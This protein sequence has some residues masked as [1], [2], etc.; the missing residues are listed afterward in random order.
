MP[1]FAGWKAPKTMGEAMRRPMCLGLFA[2]I[3]ARH[4]TDMAHA[5]LAAVAE[6]TTGRGARAED[7]LG[8]WPEETAWGEAL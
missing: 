4:E 1:L 5:A 7:P 3:A 2:W 8:E 6:A